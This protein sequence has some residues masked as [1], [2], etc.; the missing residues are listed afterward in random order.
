MTRLPFEGRFRV[1]SAEGDPYPVTVCAHPV[2]ENRNV[3]RHH[4]VRRSFLAG[5]YDWI[6]YDD[7][8]IGNIVGL[9]NEHH[10]Q[11]TDNKCA[12]IWHQLGYFAWAW[13]ND[14]VVHQTQRI[15]PQP[16][17]GTPDMSGAEYVPGVPP[18]NPEICPACKRPH[19]RKPTTLEQ[20]RERKSWTISVP[21]DEREQGADVLDTLLEEGRRI[22]ADYGMAYG[23]EKTARYF[24]LSAMMG[25][26]VQHS[27]NVLS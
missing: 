9:C 12:I 3:E 22:L 23:D 4:L 27:Q 1:K 21:V 19:R 17:I 7:V 11:I 15:E 10:L 16:P 6:E 25:L 24:I 8:R 2:C 18:E 5:A 13:M 26:F 20:A 14:G